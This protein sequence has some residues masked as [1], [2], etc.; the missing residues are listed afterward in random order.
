MTDFFAT[1]SNNYVFSLISSFTFNKLNP[2]GLYSV[3]YFRQ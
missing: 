2:F 1:K 3:D